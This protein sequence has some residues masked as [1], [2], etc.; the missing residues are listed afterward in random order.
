MATF[1]WPGTG[2]PLSCI[3]GIPHGNRVHP[4]TDRFYFRYIEPLSDDLLVLTSELWWLV[5]ADDEEV[6]D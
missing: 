1:H 4:P 6:N 3:L 2:S 5:V